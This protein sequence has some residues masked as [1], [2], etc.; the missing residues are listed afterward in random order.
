MLVR[1]D[2]IA[3]AAASTRHLYWQGQRN[4]GVE[5]A[6]AKELVHDTWRDRQLIWALALKK[7][8]Y[9][10]LGVDGFKDR[11]TSQSSAPRL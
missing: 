4:Q 2:V 10:P 9:C 5:F 6:A 8:H 7:S 1:Y 11:C 3:A